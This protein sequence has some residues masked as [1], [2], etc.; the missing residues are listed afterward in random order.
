M[1]FVININNLRIIVDW[2]LI[3]SYHFL[4]ISLFFFFKPLRQQNNLA[5]KWGLAVA[6]PSP[7]ALYL[8]SAVVKTLSKRFNAINSRISGMLMLRAFNHGTIVKFKDLCLLLQLAASQF[9]V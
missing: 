1:G 8:L 6:A 5:K 7:P 4:L 2:L 3:N 9:R